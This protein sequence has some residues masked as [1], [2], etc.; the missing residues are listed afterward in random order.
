[1]PAVYFQ[2]HTVPVKG[3][4]LGIAGNQSPKLLYRLQL[5]AQRNDPGKSIIVAWRMVDGDWFRRLL[6]NGLPDRLR[7]R[8]ESCKR[9]CNS[10]QSHHGDPKS[11]LPGV[12]A[13]VEGKDVHSVWDNVL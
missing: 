8:Y 3:L 2:E 10:S 5:T 7:S 9:F 13:I 1:V 4:A 11:L 12:A 6:G